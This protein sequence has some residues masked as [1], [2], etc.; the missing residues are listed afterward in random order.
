MN[1]QVLLNKHHF[2]TKI[3]G[4]GAYRGPI[5]CFPKIGYIEVIFEA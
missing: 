1:I 4:S 3:F 5:D 2:L